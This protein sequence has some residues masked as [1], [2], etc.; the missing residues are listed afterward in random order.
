MLNLFKLW[1][2]INNLV[3]KSLFHNL[4]LNALMRALERNT[5]CHH[6]GNE[7]YLLSFFIYYNKLDGIKSFQSSLN[8]IHVCRWITI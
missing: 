2:L 6:K 4:N 8:L 3:L 7:S 1:R 5:E